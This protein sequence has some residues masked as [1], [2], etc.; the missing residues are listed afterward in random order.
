MKN[1]SSSFSDW[2]D[3]KTQENNA[4]DK[5]IKEAYAM[6]AAGYDN[7]SWERFDELFSQIPPTSFNYYELYFFRGHKVLNHQQFQKERSANSY[8]RDML[9][10]LAAMI[11]LCPAGRKSFF[12]DLYVSYE[13]ELTDFEHD[14]RVMVQVRQF[15]KS[16]QWKECGML[17]EQEMENGTGNVA[18]GVYMADIKLIIDPSYH[19]KQEYEYFKVNYD[20]KTVQ[21]KYKNGYYGQFDLSVTDSADDGHIFYI[22]EQDPVDSKRFPQY[23]S[24]PVTNMVDS[25]LKYSKRISSLFLLPYNFFVGMLLGLKLL[26]FGMPV[27]MIACLCMEVYHIYQLLTLSRQK[28]FKKVLTKKNRV[29]FA[30][31]HYYEMERFYLANIQYMDCLP[32][33]LVGMHFM[34]D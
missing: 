5:L 19:C 17:L 13:K 33:G 24:R 4:P 26:L 28:L 10:V 30:Q 32:W 1:D 29:L 14:C 2:H 27:V 16:Q 25:W 21:R 23:D 18:W 11:E 9:P 31:L 20:E 15:Y 22:G 7:L 12:Q 3:S 6:L 34:N 8:S